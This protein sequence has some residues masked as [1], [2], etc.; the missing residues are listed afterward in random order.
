MTWDPTW[1]TIFRARDWGRY[2]PEELV[3]FIMRHY[4]QAP[5]RSK[6]RILE[7]GCG[8]GANLWF[9][10]REGFDAY[11][12]DGSETAI[13]KARDRLWEDDLHLEMRIGAQLRVGDASR[14]TE[15]AS[16]GSCDAV[17]D[18]CCLQHNRRADIQ[19]IVDQMHAVLKPGGR[20]CSMMVQ[21]GSWGDGTGTRVEP[22]TYTDI[23]EGPAAG[24][25]LTR[26]STYREV[27]EHFS[28]FGDLSIEYSGRTMHGM[29]RYWAHWV[30]EGVKA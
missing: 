14:L 30:E 22:G 5:D 7:V 8:T 29:T 21:A 25:G 1:E 9:L 24:V 6:V 20:V 23:P 26:F 11:G 3:R 13:K 12:I 15:Y 17:V 18:G 19:A 10:V 28:E 2:P 27:V 16:P 4:G